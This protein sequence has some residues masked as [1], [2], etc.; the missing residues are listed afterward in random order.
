VRLE[1]GYGGWR[2]GGSRGCRGSPAVRGPEQGEDSSLRR[3]RHQLP[4]GAAAPLQL[5]IPWLAL[6]NL[7]TP[8]YLVSLTVG[9]SG[10]RTL[11]ASH[12]GLNH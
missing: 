2:R 1:F 10:F 11:L 12:H 8:T 4:G 7:C 6:V 3:R 5:L 9:I